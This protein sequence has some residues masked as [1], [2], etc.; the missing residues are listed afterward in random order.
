MHL[1]QVWQYR[2]VPF[3]LLWAREAATALERE[4]VLDSSVHRPVLLLHEE[5]PK[6]FD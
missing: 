1:T 2:T 3:G 6:L 4:M 5:R